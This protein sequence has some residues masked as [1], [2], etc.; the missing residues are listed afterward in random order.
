V[1]FVT[2]DDPLYVIKF[3]EVFFAEYPRDELDVCG[4]TMD[5][6]FHEPIWKTARRMLRFY[7]PIDF[8]RLGL[9]FARAKLSGRSIAR[10]ARDAG[11]DEVPATSVNDG[12]YVATVRELA[13]DV[14]V[15]VAA[16]EIFRADILGAA[17]IG[18]VN[19][20]SGR[21][22]A[23][24]GM[25]PNFWQL[26][27]GERHATVTVHEMV[28]KLDAGDV[29]ATLET[30]L[31]ERDSL[32]RVITVT[33]QEGARLMIDVLRRLAAGTAEP[34]PLDMSDAGYFS[35]PQPSDVK[36]FRKRGHRML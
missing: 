30:P 34:R 18:C 15:S 20:H 8:V 31:R 21:L 22:P 6:A 13:P 35:F 25:M 12:A 26:L 3:F 27:R 7:G 17:R 29:L 36:T 19:I 28:E 33:K 32:E 2:E 10:L 4:V 1:L 11:I 24:R 14:I 9:R 23:Y 5:Q 16:P